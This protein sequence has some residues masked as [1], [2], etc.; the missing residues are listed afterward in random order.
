MTAPD[1]SARRRTDLRT[2]R[3]PA[4]IEPAALPGQELLKVE[5]LVVRRAL[6][7]ARDAAL[8]AVAV[9]PVEDPVVPGPVADRARRT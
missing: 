1:S 8:A 9:E 2:G 5:A 3:L 4:G 6:I 7:V